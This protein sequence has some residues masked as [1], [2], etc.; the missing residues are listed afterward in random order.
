MSD[1]DK[2]IIISGRKIC[3]VTGF[4]MI[5]ASVILLICGLFQGNIEWD[6]ILIAFIAGFMCLFA[7]RM[8]KNGKY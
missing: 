1:K 2:N 5:L 8:L 3:Q 4:I 7:S 6:Y